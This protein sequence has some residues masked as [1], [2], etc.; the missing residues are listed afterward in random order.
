MARH[1]FLRELTHEINNPMTVI[2][3][4]AEFLASSETIDERDQRRAQAILRASER[5]GDLLQGLS[6]LSQ[7]SDPQ[8]P[9]PCSRSTWSRSSRRRSRR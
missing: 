7:V 9:P 4:N 8:H 2:A 5:L 1:W 3:A 6:M